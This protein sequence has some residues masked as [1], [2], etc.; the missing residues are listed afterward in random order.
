MSKNA[1][2]HLAIKNMSEDR[3]IDVANA[4]FPVLPEHITKNWNE[5]YLKRKY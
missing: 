5:M 4:T 2:G 1:Y 3:K